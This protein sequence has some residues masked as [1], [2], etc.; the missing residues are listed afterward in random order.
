MNKKYEN[1]EISKNTI[2]SEL[3]IEMRR[4]RDYQLEISKWYTTVLLAIIGAILTIKFTYSE[5]MLAKVISNIFWVKLT[6]IG[7][8]MVIGFSGI[9]SILYSHWRYTGIKE[10]VYKYLEPEWRKLSKGE[11]DL[12]KIMKIIK[13]HLCILFTLFLLTAA[14]LII[15]TIK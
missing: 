7:V 3:C 8:V 6:I 10:Y 14:I 4:H 15:I 13:P 2:Y 11:E 1:N 12:N 5:S 9:Y